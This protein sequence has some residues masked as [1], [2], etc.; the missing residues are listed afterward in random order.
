MGKRSADKQRPDGRTL[1]RDPSPGSRKADGTELLA[2]ASVGVGSFKN[3]RTKVRNH[4]PADTLPAA[5]ATLRGSHS[6]RQVS[7][8]PVHGCGR[9]WKGKQDV[10]IL[11][12]K[13]VDIP[14]RDRIKICVWASVPGSSPACFP[15]FPHLKMVAGNLCSSA[16]RMRV[17]VAGDSFTRPLCQHATTRELISWL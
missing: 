8:A 12:G 13:R 3:G 15:I 16:R 2:L 5:G 9:G 4:F 14:A 11:D 10:V 1:G 6:F 7:Y 17:H